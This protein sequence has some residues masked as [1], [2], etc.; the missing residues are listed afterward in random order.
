MLAVLIGVTIVTALVLVWKYLS[1]INK[2][3]ASKGIPHTKPVLFFGNSWQLISQKKTMSEV[4]KEAYEKFPNSPL[5]GFYDF[6]K[7][8][9]I[10]RDIE[11]VERVMI[12]DFQHFTDHGFGVADEA[13]NPLDINLFN[14]TGKKWKA[15]RTKLSPIF[16]T[17]KLRYMLP[18]IKD[19][20]ETLIELLEKKKDQ[21]EL[22]DSYQRFAMDVIAS[23]AFGISPN[24]MKADGDSEFH[25]MGK[26]AF[27]F[28]LNQWFRFFLHTCFPKVAKALK[29]Q[30]NNP[31]VSK[32]FCGIVRDTLAFRRTNNQTRVD[33]VQLLLTLQQK[34]SVEFE[35]EGTDDDY[36]KTS[37]NKE[38]M[39]NMESYELTDE[40][41]VGHAFIF[42]VAG[43]EATAN[44][45]MFTAYEFAMN[46]DVQAMA[47][48]EVARVFK[49]R[50]GVMDYDT[51]KE[52][53]YLGQC[54]K[55]TM[56]VHSLVPMLFRV[57]TKK[58]TFPGT[59]LTIEPGQTLYVPISGIHKD[60]NYYP[61]PDEYKPE[62]FGP[63]VTRPNCSFIPFGDGPRICIAMRFV[64]MEVK[65]SLARILLQ[66]SISL[67]PKTIL[68][69]KL[70]PKNFT[71]TPLNP[72]YFKLTKRDNAPATVK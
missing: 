22:K 40:A 48:A 12:K 38:E 50:N 3:W 65:L 56:R 52:M 7:P 41:L 32:Y 61:D 28:S 66:Y 24:T 71:D 35:G 18:Q 36:L 2:F 13:S 46:P 37:L 16:T 33:F 49:E 30:Q 58:Y 14:M 27:Q 26:T 43:F 55:E 53:T 69:L 5:I 23:C 15:M 31:A 44:V 42:L 1:N 64:L 54:V 68:P 4:Y 39:K 20:S 6:M 57:C 70:D 51:I 8:V 62:R 59:S 47:A 25:R 45:M 21:V 11:L 9:I 63:D 34:G 29:V 17:G 67:D 10:V 60:P 19:L 72:L